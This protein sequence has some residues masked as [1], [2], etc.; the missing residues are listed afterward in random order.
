MS[1][2]IGKDFIDKQAI[3]AAPEHDRPRHISPS[4]AILLLRQLTSALAAV[5]R[6]GIVHRWVKPSN[7]LLT[8]KEGGS[9]RLADFSMAKFPGVN[10]PLPDIWVD[11]GPY[12]APEQWENAS[13]VGPEAD[14]YSIGALAYRFIMG[15]SPQG[16]IQE[17]ETP[18]DVPEQ[19]WTFIQAALNPDPQKRPA[20][21]GAVVPMLE[22]IQLIPKP[23]RERVVLSRQ[24]G[25]KSSVHLS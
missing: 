7:I 5:H 2:E 12:T 4:R 3:E 19:L 25:G 11:R 10:P 22:G 24:A 8:A 17:M 18:E 20:N 14:V 9:I 1:F 15:F 23:K 6:R 13:S 16:D 21:A